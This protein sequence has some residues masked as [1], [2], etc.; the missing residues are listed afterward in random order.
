[1]DEDFEQELYWM[2]RP[3]DYNVFE[4]RQLD[5]DREAGEYD[6]DEAD[7]ADTPMSLMEDDSYE[8]ALFGADC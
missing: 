2:D 8:T 3:D 5:L 6:F 7:E 4:E 1:M